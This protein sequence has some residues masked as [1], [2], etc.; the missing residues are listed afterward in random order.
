MDKILI[1]G[2]EIV[3]G[4]SGAAPLSEE[5]LE[6]ASG[7][8]GENGRNYSRLVCTDCGYASWWGI[9]SQEKNYIINLHYSQTGHF[10]YH[11]ESKYFES[12]P[13]AAPEV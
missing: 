12:D 7:G 6:C 8:A 1:D 4:E 10:K 2:K 3:S 13:N 5:E 9:K 11:S